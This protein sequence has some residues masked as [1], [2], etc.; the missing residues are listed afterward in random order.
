MYLHL[1]AYVLHNCLYI[2]LLNK[3]KSNQTLCSGIFRKKYV[4]LEN[5]TFNR[6]QR[7]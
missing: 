3:L 4:F 2:I 5:C 1:G 7:K 6:N